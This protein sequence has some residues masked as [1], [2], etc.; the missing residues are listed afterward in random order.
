MG[1]LQ[2]RRGDFHQ[3]TFTLEHALE[4]C[5]GVESPL[6]TYVV[7][8]ALGYAYARSG[9]STEAIPLLEEAV[10]RPEVERGAE[11]KLGKPVRPVPA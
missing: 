7:T 4:V 8:S 9:R 2:L 5:Q 6:L 10:E 11:A 1:L 3:T